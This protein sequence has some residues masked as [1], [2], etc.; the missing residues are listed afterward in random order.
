MVDCRIVE[1]ADEFIK[2]KNMEQAEACHK[3]S[4]FHAR[5]QGTALKTY[6]CSTAQPKQES[7]QKT[8]RTPSERGVLRKGI[9]CTCFYRVRNL[10][11]GKALIEYCDEHTHLGDINMMPCDEDTVNIIKNM[12]IEKH[13][14]KH[15]LDHFNKIGDAHGGKLLSYNCT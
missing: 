8:Y 11:N 4:L 5:S 3:I 1:S 12:L 10:K 7:R 15:I 13:T 2:T 9:A 6:I 14:T